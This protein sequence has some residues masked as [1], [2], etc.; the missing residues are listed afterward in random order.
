MGIT[1]KIPANLKSGQYK[2]RATGSGGL[3]FTDETTVQ[4]NSK[5]VSL[6]IQTDK[7]MYKPGQTVHFRAFGIYP[8]LRLYTGNMT[9]EIF[10]SKSNKIKQWTNVQPTGGVYTNYIEITDQPIM[11]DWKVKVIAGNMNHEQVFTIAEYGKIIFVVVILTIGAQPLTFYN[12]RELIFFCKF[13][14]QM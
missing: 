6:F 9:I 11:G 14:S 8:N 10:D 12:T 5:S 3:T 13:M 7:A 4:F 1:L 2:L